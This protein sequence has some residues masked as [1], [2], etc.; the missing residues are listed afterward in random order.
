MPGQHTSTSGWERWALFLSR[1][2]SNGTMGQQVLRSDAYERRP[3]DPSS[4][5]SW[6]T[7]IGTGYGVIQEYVLA[8]HAVPWLNTDC[9]KLPDL[10]KS[11][12]VA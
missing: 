5:A 2:P 1:K 8:T 9:I 12:E 6:Q 3:V 7:V 4:A 11:L 10:V